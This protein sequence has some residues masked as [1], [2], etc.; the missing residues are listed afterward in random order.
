MR[1]VVISNGPSAHLFEQTD[2]SVYDTVI[3]VNRAASLWPCKWWSVIDWPMFAEFAPIGTPKLFT[4]ASMPR[5]LQE[6]AKK[7]AVER[8]QA[9]LWDGQVL[10]HESLGRPWV[11]DDCPPW[12]CYSGVAA[13][14]LAWHLRANTV[15]LYGFDMAGDDDCAGKTNHTRG[16]DRWRHERRIFDGIMKVYVRD[17]IK[18]ER[19]TDAAS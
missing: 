11:P 19:H 16:E 1:V 4:R 8:M 6:G 10:T 2:R 15:D 12:N 9:L 14:I 7:D 3:G 17:G 13:L 18:V 5:H